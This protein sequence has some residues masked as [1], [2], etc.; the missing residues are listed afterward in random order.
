[1]NIFQQLLLKITTLLIPSDTIR[2]YIDSKNFEIS[3]TWS[4]NE[5]VHEA[6]LRNMPIKYDE[7]TKTII[8]QD[9]LQ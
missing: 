4:I 8:L 1:M 3:I 2:R 5:F 7:H 9:K 6:N